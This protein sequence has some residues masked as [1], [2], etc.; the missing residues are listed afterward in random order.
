MG[1][2]VLL[3]VSSRHEVLDEAS[4]VVRH[5][6]EDPPT[7]EEFDAV[8]HR[9]GLEPWDVA[10]INE[11]VAEVL[12]QPGQLRV[13]ELREAVAAQA[14]HTAYRPSR[15]VHRRDPKGCTG[16]RF[17]TASGSKAPVLG[18]DATSAT[19]RRILGVPLVV[20]QYV[21]ADTG[22]LLL[23][24]EHGVRHGHHRRPGHGRVAH[25]C[26]R[27]RGGQDPAASG[28]QGEVERA[29][30]HVNPQP[31][32]RQSAASA[33]SRWETARPGSSSSLS[34]RITSQSTSWSSGSR[35]LK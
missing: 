31:P 19:A 35:R 17:K 13:D 10:R 29:R 8:L 20:S 12:G 11:P 23:A 5:Y 26:R 30:A 14:R 18:T 1:Q 9:L 4:Y 2:S 24:V 33:V 15:P 22:D 3:E 21:A 7:A 34:S 28:D 32:R 16:L 27:G 6:L 25:R